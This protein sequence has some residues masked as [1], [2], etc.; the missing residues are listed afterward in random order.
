M[1][2]SIHYRKD[3]GYWYVQWYTPEKTYKISRYKGEM[4]YHKKIARKLLS[5]MQSD[6]E[7]DVFRIEKFTKK[8]WTDTIPYLKQWLKTIKS[9][10]SPATYKDYSNSI[11]NHLAPFFRE[12][13]FQLHEIQYDVLRKLLS[14]INRSGKGKANVMYCLH[15]CMMY[16]WKSQ[17]IPAMPPFPEKKLYDIKTPSIK[18]DKYEV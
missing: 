2:G 4:M 10:L 15:A 6:F 16:A 7:N 17:R 5:V 1:K 8:G 3:R 11:R 12:H 14:S 18:G 9:E 13:Q